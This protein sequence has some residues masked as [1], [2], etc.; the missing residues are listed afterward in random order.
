MYIHNI[1][2]KYDHAN[3]YMQTHSKMTVVILTKPNSLWKNW[4]AF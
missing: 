3:T 1:V 2:E 4:N